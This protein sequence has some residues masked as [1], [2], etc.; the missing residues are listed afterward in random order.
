MVDCASHADFTELQRL[1]GN[2]NR[3]TCR[4]VRRPMV[5]ESPSAKHWL[6]SEFEHCGDS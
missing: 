6:P 3:F 4:R 1:S 2:A 5:G